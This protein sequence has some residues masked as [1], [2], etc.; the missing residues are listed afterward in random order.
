[1]ER[2][3]GIVFSA[4]DRG[5]RARRGGVRCFASILYLGALVTVQF[6]FFLDPSLLILVLLLPFTAY[7]SPLSLVNLPADLF[8]L[9]RHF[10]DDVA[11]KGVE[12]LLVE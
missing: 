11:A 9:P 1:M 7:V 2:A 4:D 10:I 8:R 12:E 6:L 5:N 3:V